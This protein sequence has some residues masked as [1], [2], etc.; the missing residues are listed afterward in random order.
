LA[1]FPA[2]A[3]AVQQA[4]LDFFALEGD[5]H[6]LLAAATNAGLLTRRTNPLRAMSAVRQSY[7]TLAGSLA[8]DLS[9]PSLRDTEFLLNQLP[10][11]LYGEDLAEFLSIPSAIAAVIPLVPSRYRP[12]IGF[13]AG[14]AFVPGYNRLTYA[15]A[16][17]AAW[18]LFR[19]A[20][21]RWRVA[22]LGLPARAVVGRPLASWTERPVLNGF[23]QHVVSRPADWGANVHVTGWWYPEDPGWRPPAELVH[24]LDTGPP[25]VFLGFGSMLVADKAQATATLV[26]AIRLSGRRAI[27]HA[28]W[29]G[30][31]ADLPPHILPITY[32]PY[33]WL[34]PQMAAVVHHGG[35]G[36]TGFALRSGVPSLVVPFGFD[37][38]YW[39]QRTAELGAGPPPIPFPKLTAVKLA[40]AI[41]QAI[42]NPAIQQQ[43][44]LVGQ[45]VAAERGLA[46]A[47]AIISELTC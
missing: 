40:A 19:P 2:F 29:A 43:A 47:V 23:S 46:Q 22:E 12:F 10:G 7:A 9:D 16:A 3:D 6:S 8:R 36:T 32:A 39:G 1:T 27:L 25:P 26:E 17:Q 45:K 38:Y 5:A 31:G 28:G 18:L 33:G 14:P 24:F 44:R 30:L 41:D 34:F 37:Q 11:N 35:S 15:I 42:T 21:N 13:P 20:V 4:G